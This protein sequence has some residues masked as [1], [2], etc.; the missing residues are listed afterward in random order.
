MR[1]GRKRWWDKMALLNPLRLTYPLLVLAVACIAVAAIVLLL[2]TRRHGAGADMDEPK[3][4]KARVTKQ[5]DVRTHAEL[6][7]TSNC[8]LKA[9]QDVLEGSAH[10]FRASLVF[11][12]FAL[13]AYLNWHGEHLIPHWQYLER[14]TPRE[15]LDLLASLSEVT[16]DYGSRP[17]QIVKDLY[18]FRNDIAHGKPENISSETSEDVDEFLDAKLST[19]IKTDWERFCTE[20]NAVRAKEDVKEIASALYN[21]ANMKDKSDGPYGPFAMGFQVHGADLS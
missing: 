11:R 5:R 18:G 6:W 13:E 1:V 4:K 19:F 10:Q 7:H 2:R 16:P 12:A 14:L 3:V 15:K 9:G 8:L 21:G 20:E 17:W